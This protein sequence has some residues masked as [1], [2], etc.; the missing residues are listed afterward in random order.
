MLYKIYITLILTFATIF[1]HF[2]ENKIKIF[3]VHDNWD[4]ILN[5]L[6]VIKIWEFISYELHI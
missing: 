3:Y 1:R 4:T 2:K 5:C 6:T